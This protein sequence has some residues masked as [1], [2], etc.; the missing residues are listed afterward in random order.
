MGER[1]LIGGKDVNE[2][3]QFSCRGN[4]FWG[5]VCLPVFLGES[6]CK[7]CEVVTI[8]PQK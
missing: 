1:R 8:F 3:I 6:V 7:A 5:W 2:E 4:L